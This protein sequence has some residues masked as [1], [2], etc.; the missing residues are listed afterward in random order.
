MERKAAYLRNKEYIPVLPFFIVEARDVVTYT[1]TDVDPRDFTSIRR[2][3]GD[4]L[5]HYYRDS[6][7]VDNLLNVEATEFADLNAEIADVLA[8][9]YIDTATWGLA[10]WERICGLLT[11][12]TKPIEQRR[13][14]IK[15]KLRGVGTV[16]AAM[17]KNVAESF[18][19]GEVAV[20]EDNATYTVTIKFV[21]TRGEPANLD[22]I[23]NALR[24][25]I[26]AHLA[27]NFSFTY[28]TWN[29]LDAKALTW[30]DLD[31]LNLTWDEFEVLE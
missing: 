6:R 4:Y 13:S 9:F 19:N 24:E 14:V 28:M 18:D 17:I 1:K 30:D 22:D 12:E 8:Q 10:N 2:D 27:V 3:I 20:I 21:S 23:Q 26:P 16:T 29:A 7:T 5:P 25:I 11:D 31:A 15:S